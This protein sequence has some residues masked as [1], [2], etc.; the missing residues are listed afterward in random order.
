MW[1]RFAPVVSADGQVILY[2]EELTFEEGEFLTLQTATAIP[3]PP[4]WATVVGEGYRLSATGG[5]PELRG[6]S[7]SFGY[8]GSEVPPGEEGWL[9][10]YYWDG[11]EWEQLETNLVE[12][13]SS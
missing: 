5:A 2:G 4:A 6:T 12:L 3:S 1:S 9:K 8:L 13:Y 7:I 10:V 11:A